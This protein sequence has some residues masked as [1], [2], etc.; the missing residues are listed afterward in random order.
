MMPDNSSFLMME[1]RSLVQPAEK[2]SYGMSMMA[3]CYKV[4]QSGPLTR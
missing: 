4:N 3:I 1:Q 2:Y